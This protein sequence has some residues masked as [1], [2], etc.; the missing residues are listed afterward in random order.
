VLIGEGLLFGPKAKIG[1]EFEG[2]LEPKTE[3]E[4]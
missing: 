3:E 2:V 1:F 4:F